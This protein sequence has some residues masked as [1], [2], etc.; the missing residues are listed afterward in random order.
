MEENLDILREIGAQQIHKDT[1]ISKEYLQA[2]IHG[3]FDGMSSVQLNGFISILEKEYRVDLS[4]LKREA[5]R[6]FVEEV[7]ES[8][9]PSKIFVTSQREKKNSQMY[10]WVGV[11]VFLAVLYYS[12]GYVSSESS[13]E[14]ETD[15]SLVENVQE[16]VPIPDTQELDV[17]AVTQTTE[18]KAIPEEE[19]ADVVVEAEALVATVAAEEIILEETPVQEV[20]TLKILPVN[21]I[22]AGYIN[23]KT[24]AKRQ[25]VFK[26]EFAL[27]VEK[28]WLL[29]FGEGTV[30]LEVNSQK[31]KFSSR[32]VMR[33]KYVDGKFEKITTEEFKSLNKGSKW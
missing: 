25:K 15:N 23:I 29:L 2:I 6:Y 11:I 3:S 14:Q 22:W 12:F 4:E 26:K 8:A 31:K 28:D 17:V 10:I 19:A 33:F 7:H 24:N 32:K 5:A 27:D 16:I 1:H 9:N 30:Y 13:V 20:K 18:V 21:K